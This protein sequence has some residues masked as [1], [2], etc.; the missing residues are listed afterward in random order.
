MDELDRIDLDDMSRDRADVLTKRAK[1][2]PDPDV[3]G[4]AE[5]TVYVVLALSDDEP[6]D[7]VWFPRGQWVAVDGD[8][9]IQ[10]VIDDGGHDGGVY[11]AVA[12]RYFKPRTVRVETVRQARF[13]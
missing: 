2:E 6:D 11:V 3:T 1:E 9:A 13:V 12:L 5:G 10:D 7:Q 8:T 4:E